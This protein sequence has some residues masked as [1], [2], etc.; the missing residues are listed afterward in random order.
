MARCC[1][2][3]LSKAAKVLCGGGYSGENFAMR[4]GC[5]PERKWKRQNA[6]NR[7]CGLSHPFAALPK[8]RVVERGF[9]RRE[10][11]RRLWK[12]GERKL[13]NTLLMTTLAFISLLL[14]RY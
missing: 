12:N 13:R 5:F 14:K 9:A 3:N 7:V 1:A 4:R 6:T 8:R 11:Y 10:K 2:P